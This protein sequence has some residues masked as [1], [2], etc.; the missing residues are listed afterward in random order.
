M[1]SLYKQEHVHYC[2][3]PVAH[4]CFWV[5][6]SYTGGMHSSTL[7]SV[8]AAVQYDILIC[9]HSHKYMIELTIKQTQHVQLI[10]QNSWT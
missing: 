2:Q 6:P 8:A 10:Q 4:L 1:I 3:R 7:D 9:F 5:L